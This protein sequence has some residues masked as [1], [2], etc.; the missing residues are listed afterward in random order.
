MVGQNL[1]EILYF[2]HELLFMYLIHH[3]KQYHVIVSPKVAQ[4]FFEKDA[5]G[6][7][8]SKKKKK[9]SSTKYK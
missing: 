5:H 9:K 1:S 6:F 4:K 3:I 8:K 2:R 7:N